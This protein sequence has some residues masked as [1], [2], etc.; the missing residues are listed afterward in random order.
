MTNK[1]VRENEM[2]NVTG[3]G[4]QGLRRLLICGMLL[5]GA[6]AAPAA[7]A[8]S[9]L[10]GASIGDV[11]QHSYSVGGPIATTNDSDTGFRV[12][13][14]YMFTPWFGGVLSY[15]DLGSPNYDGPAFGGFTDKL[16]ADAIDLSFIAAISPGDQDTFSTFAT[17]GVFHFNQDVHY[18]DSTGVFNYHD[19]G[20]SLSYGIGIQ[21]K[22]AS[23]YG[24]HL[25]WQRFTNVGDNG[26]SGHEYDRDM[27]ELGFEMHFGK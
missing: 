26:N 2:R 6:A 24:V 18:T 9:W 17:I 13:G 8:Q 15:V 12:F 1:N 21:A 19:S 3:N 11:K 25:G 16:D 23:I 4:R 14:G 27:V 22:F 7:I 5:S 20:T 10:A